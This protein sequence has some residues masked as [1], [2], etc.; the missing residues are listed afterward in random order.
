MFWTENRIKSS[1]LFF[2][3]KIMKTDMMISFEQHKMK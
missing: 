3:I 1:V 2:L